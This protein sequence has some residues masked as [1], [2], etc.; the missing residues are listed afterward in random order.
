[1][2]LSDVG[3][4]L[5]RPDTVD[6]E[7]SLCLLYS[8]YTNTPLFLEIVRTTH[9]H[10]TPIHTHTHTH[11]HTFTCKRTHIHTHTHTHTYTH[12]QCVW[13]CIT[14][15][16]THTHTHIHTHLHLPLTLFLHQET[17]PEAVR[18]QSLPC[19]WPRALSSIERSEVDAWFG[20]RL[21]NYLGF[22][23]RDLLTSPATQNA[24]CLAFQKLYVY[25]RTT[26][27]HRGWARLSSQGA[28]VQLGRHS[29]RAGLSLSSLEHLFRTTFF[30]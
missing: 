5:R 1:M 27:D 2:P 16:Y 18:R 29:V 14:H 24:T 30:F 4:L 3:E 26:A 8:L 12:T 20:R 21:L 15:P 23:T 13:V 6:D 28:L 17:L 19:V 9:T 11:T 22:L 25:H 7:D 10:N